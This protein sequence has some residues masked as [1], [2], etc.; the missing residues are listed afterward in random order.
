[1]SSVR[2]RVGNVN[3]RLA[4]QEEGSMA[5][6]VETKNLADLYNLPPVDGPR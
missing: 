3:G 4:D 1:M 5:T 2:Q 6:I